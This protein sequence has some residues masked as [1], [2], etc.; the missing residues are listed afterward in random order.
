MMLET[1]FKILIFLSFTTMIACSSKENK[2]SDQQTLTE[3][4][5]NTNIV[6]DA[7]DLK[8]AFDNKEDITS[9]TLFDDTALPDSILLL[10]NLRHLSLESYSSIQNI[11]PKIY[12]LPNLERLSISGNL[13]S[14]HPELVNAQKLKYL[15]L[16]NNMLNK[17]PSVIF[18]LRNLIQLDLYFNLISS[19]PIDIKELN[20]LE[21]LDL[22]GNPFSEE[23]IEKYKKEYSY[24]KT[25]G[26]GSVEE[27]E[28][29]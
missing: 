1:K 24:I 2:N 3:V 21:V 15:D 9:L 13:K 26:I 29:E 16:G 6:T 23:N 7:R 8:T 27:D 18:Q 19:I 20:K 11:N 25:F 12:S 17:I 22:Y 28:E 5:T 4:K 10:K 14:I